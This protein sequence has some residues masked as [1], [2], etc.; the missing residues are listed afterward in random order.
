LITL[1]VSEDVSMTTINT[2]YS[3]ALLPRLQ[4]FLRKPWRE[5]VASAKHHFRTAVAR[6]PTP[7]RLPLG[8]W[9]L[10]RNDGIGASLLK[11]EFENRERAFV[12]WF[13]QPGMTAL[14][15]GAHQGCYTLL[16][17][18]RVGRAGKVVAFEPSP[19]ERRALRL[20]LLLNWCDNV[21]VQAT[22]LGSEETEE[23]LHLV[24][25]LETGCNSLRAPVLAGGTSRPV[26]VRVT[27]LDRWLCDHKVEH[28][29]FIKLDVE[30]AEL[31]VLRGAPEL[32]SRYPRP[33]I[34]AEVANIR[35]APW[36]YR[37][38]EIVT[39]LENAGYHWYEI[40]EGG[41]L[42][43]VGKIHERETNLVAVPSE[44]IDQVLHR[45]AQAC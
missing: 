9:F 23:V 41:R 11:G 33:V 42:V 26:R 27:R 20:N 19:R 30:G 24:E 22:A 36:G 40:L 25:G 44:R 21:T 18:K 31:S 4:R 13:L 3:S 12:S 17:A 37:A 32:L 14:D 38:S 6:I 7:V 35:T 10:A 16:A 29:D 43:A 34:L 5:K 1:R 28:V 8:V 39:A 45:K 15:L 2:G